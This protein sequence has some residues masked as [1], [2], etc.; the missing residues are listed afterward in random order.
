MYRRQLTE[1]FKKDTKKIKGNSLL[2]KRLQK[3]MVEVL[4]NPHHYKPLR[5]VLKNR[6][7]VHIDSFVLIFEL[8]EV[9]RVVIFR[10]FKHHDNAYK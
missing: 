4:E 6:R 9:E 5:N 7:R 3:K 2:G 10:Q 1:N 8:N